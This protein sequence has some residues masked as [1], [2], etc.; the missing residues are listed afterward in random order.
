MKRENWEPDFDDEPR[1]DGKSSLDLFN[2]G[3]KA[4]EAERRNRWPD[5]IIPCKGV[6]REIQDRFRR[7]W[8]NTVTYRL[9]SV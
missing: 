9:V 8:E 1:I 2:E 5:G 6:E 7:E 4:A 3:C